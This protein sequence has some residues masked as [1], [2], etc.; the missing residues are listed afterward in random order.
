M[1]ENAKGHIH[2]L[3]QT[4]NNAV[5]IFAEL[6][7]EVV[8]GPE[9]ETE[10]YNFDALNVPKDHPSR[11][12]QDTF[13]L[14]GNQKEQVTIDQKQLTESQ[15]SNINGQKFLMRTHTSPVQV[16]Y[17]EK[18]KPPFRIIVPGKVFRHE[19][20]DATHEVQF[21]QIEGLVVGEDISLANLKGTLELFFK[22]LFGEKTAIR[23]RPSFFPFV[24][25]GVE[26]DVS[27]F[28]CGGLGCSL[29]KKTGFI[30]VMGAGMVH[31]NVLNNAG[32]DSRKYRGFAF[33]VGVD[34]LVMLKYGIDDVRLLYAG[35]LRLV[36][37]F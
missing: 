30:E 29:C 26:I 10:S 11:D 18:N 15:R 14:K 13:W 9:I 4:I 6:G 35:D 36:N 32:I 23:F 7:F 28:K 31:P 2:P 19:A 16:R 37:Q 25:P 33:G 22:K 24:E 17:M 34:R 27:C 12:M 3:T 20:T 1:K 21:H 8:D 5:S